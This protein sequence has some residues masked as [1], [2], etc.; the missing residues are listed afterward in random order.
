MC[1]AR[2]IGV[3]VGVGD[4]GR[5]AV[6]EQGVLLSGDITVHVGLGGEV[7]AARNKLAD[8]NLA[9]FNNER[10]DGPGQTAR[11]AQLGILLRHE[12]VR[13]RAAVA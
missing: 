9:V 11:G 1:D 6:G 4:A 12:E 3:E 5:H 13:A 8:G 2:E 7:G 10:A